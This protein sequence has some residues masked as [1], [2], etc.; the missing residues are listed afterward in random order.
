MSAFI[1][2]IIMD[3]DNSIFKFNKIIRKYP[4]HQ[5]LDYAYYMIAMN[6]YEQINHHELDG[7]FNEMALEAFNQVILRF[8]ESKYAK[9]SI[10]KTI[11]I[12]SNKAAK[13]MEIGRFY[14]NEKKYTAALNRFKIVVDEY[15]MTKFTPEALHR[16]VEAYY[17]MGLVDE[18]KKTAAVLG[19]NYPDSEWYGYSYKLIKK[20]EKKTSIF[21]KVK[22]IFN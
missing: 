21:N 4:S 5:E 12:K 2:Y 1:D 17:E 22:N 8:P 11:L 18:S 10:Q 14:L 16:M 15:S 7:K 19:Y 13:H 9:D 20:I 6:N 3:Y